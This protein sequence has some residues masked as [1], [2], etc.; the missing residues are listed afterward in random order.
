[1]LVQENFVIFLPNVYA[2]N[3]HNFAK[4]NNFIN[5]KFLEIKTDFSNLTFV[6]LSTLQKFL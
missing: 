2:I 1:M 6:F 4:K 5:I 3:L